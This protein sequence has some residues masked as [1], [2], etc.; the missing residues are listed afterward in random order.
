MNVSDCHLIKL[1]IITHLWPDWLL[2]LPRTQTSR[3]FVSMKICARA[4]EGGRRKR[5]RLRLSSF[6]IPWSIALRQQSL[7]FSRSPLCENRSVSGGSSYFYIST[8]FLFSLFISIF[9]S[10]VGLKGHDNTTPKHEWMNELSHRDNGHALDQPA[11]C[12]FCDQFFIS[13]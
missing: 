7:V 5:A 2:L 13:S 8:F 12:K 3:L 10:T 4:K 9:V 1:E 6:S 11:E